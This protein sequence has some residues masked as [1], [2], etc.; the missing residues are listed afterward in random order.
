MLYGRPSGELDDFNN[1]LGELPVHHRVVTAGNHDVPITA[2]VEMWRKRLSNATLLIHGGV[3]IEGVHTWGS[4][5][6]RVDGT[7]GI[8]MK[9]RVTPS[10]RMFPL[11]PRLISSSPTVFS[12]DPG[13]RTGLRWTPA[14]CHSLA[15]SPHSST[16][17]A[18]TG[19]THSPYLAR[20]C[21]C[22][23]QL[24]TLAGHRKPEPACWASRISLL[25]R[26]IWKAAK[27]R[28]SGP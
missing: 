19:R 22:S 8:L 15:S 16:L 5:V 13:W 28:L 25:L 3:N 9:R 18:L 7:F 17:T 10:T 23:T 11:I 24:C 20:E 27:E 21:S 6:T 14:G 2:D 12:W 26:C 1:W 4:P